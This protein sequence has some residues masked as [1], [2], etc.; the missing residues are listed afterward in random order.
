[1]WKLAT[2]NQLDGLDIHSIAGLI[3]MVKMGVVDRKLT[4]EI[5]LD[6]LVL[7]FCPFIYGSMERKALIYR[8]SYDFGMIAEF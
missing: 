6:C 5:V 8:F 2:G 4:R 3:S 7:S 1:M